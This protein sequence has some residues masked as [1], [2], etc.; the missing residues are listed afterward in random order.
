ML[1]ANNILIPRMEQN[2]QMDSK[3]QKI[4]QLK[5]MLYLRRSKIILV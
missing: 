3:E 5:K 1:Q 4:L 2:N